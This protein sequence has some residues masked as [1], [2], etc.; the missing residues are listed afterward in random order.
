MKIPLSIKDKKECD[1][2]I[3]DNYSKEKIEN[4]VFH[5]EYYY[6]KDKNKYLIKISYSK[7]QLNFKE[8]LGR[9]LNGIKDTKFWKIE[10]DRID[11]NGNFVYHCMTTSPGSNEGIEIQKIFE[12]INDSIK[13]KI[14]AFLKKHKYNNVYVKYKNL[15]F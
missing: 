12:S 10:V 14:I 4:M 9:V 7:E 6:P 15:K 8:K 5:F 13:E 1:R 2:L 11:E 3:I